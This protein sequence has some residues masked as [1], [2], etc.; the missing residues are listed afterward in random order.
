MKQINEI[1]RLQQL[2][3]ILKENNETNIIQE[4]ENN[5]KE[6]IESFRDYYTDM[7]D[8]DVIPFDENRC[9]FRVEGELIRLYIDGEL[10][11][12]QWFS[13][14]PTFLSQEIV[15]D[16]PVEIFN[17]NNGNILYVSTDASDT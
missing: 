11:S 4:L 10:L 1:K 12:P 14:N 16:D 7:E 9:E 3:G 17:F 8:D 5:K 6:I 15:E 13:L 2:A